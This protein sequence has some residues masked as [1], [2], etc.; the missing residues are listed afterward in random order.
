[1]LI[2][3]AILRNVEEANK[4]CIV[5]KALAGAEIKLAVK[6]IL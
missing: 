6:I 2:K 4:N 1:M 5:S 3:V